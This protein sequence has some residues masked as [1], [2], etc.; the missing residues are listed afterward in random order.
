M[1][2]AVQPPRLA[3][4]FLKLICPEHLF[5]EIEGDLV[6]KFNRDVKTI[7]EKRAKWRLLWNVIR[8]FRPGI[9][10]R[11]KLTMNV[12]QSNMLV[13]N[14][15]FTWRHL[16]KQKLTTA[17]HVIGLTLGISVC[18]LIALFIDQQNS[19]DGYHKNASRIFRVNSIFTEGGINMNLYATPLP[20]SQAIHESITGVEHTSSV[21][22]LF[23]TVVETAPGKLFQEDRILLTDQEYLDIFNIA[24]IAG[25]ARKSLSF[26]HQAIL[27]KSIARKY[28][29][30]DNPIGKTIKLQSK[31]EFTVAAIMQDAP[32]NTSLPASIILP[33]TQGSELTEH[34]DTWYFGGFSWVKLQ[35]STYLLLPSGGDYEK[36]KSQ[37]MQLA[38]QKINANPTLNE[39]IH[40]AFEL[41]SLRDIHFDTDGFGGGPWVSAMNKSWL[42]FFTGIGLLVL[43]LACVNFLNISTAKAATR[44]K[45][46]GIRKSIGAQRKQLIAQFL[47]EAF[48]LVSIASLL[49][50][51]I[52]SVSINFFGDLF[53]PG[54]TIETILSLHSGLWLLASIVGIVLLAGFYPAL[55]ISRFNLVSTLK[56]SFAISSTRGN[57]LFRKSLVAVQFIIS[58]VLIVSV[59]TISEQVRYMHNKPLGLEKDNILS[60][61]VPEIKQG[62]ALAQELLRITGIKEVS[63]SRSAPI[64]LDH[65]WNSISQTASSDKRFSVCAIYGDENFTSFYGLKLLIGRTLVPT[66]FIPD[67]LRKATTANK[68]VV[69]EKLLADLE[70]GTPAEAIGKQFWWGGPAEIIGVVADFNTEPLRYAISPTILTQH[71]DL[72]AQINIKLNPENYAVALATVET[73]W[74]K[75]FPDKVF[76]AAFLDEQINNFYQQED[77]IYNLFKVFALLAIS[78]SCL[79]LWGLV[80]FI[81]QLRTREIGIRKVM[82]ASLRSIAWILSKDFFATVSIAFVI[83]APLA[84]LLMDWI[85]AKVA[86]RIDIGWGIFS[87]AALSI[88][89]AVIVTISTQVIRTAKANPVNALKSE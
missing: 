64:S 57:A 82:G 77:K 80:V 37:L 36:V 8:F 15:H 43:V 58:G 60:L 49:S 67:S 85:L 1:N 48:V 35:A 2:S 42:W 79:G 87:L 13:A 81:T 54:V 84:F 40:A 78:I 59:L 12:T 68:V 56:S 7:G 4:K 21:R 70:L 75:F 72:F 38:N 18:M 25:D 83:A 11:N 46:V 41:Q 6:Q 31:F 26:P 32:S 10:L 88:I 74:K 39:K 3:L 61:E 73:T 86:Y 44:A 20:L 71:P 22:T 17:I 55:A 28:F 30:D 9:L 34:G 24:I 19:F 52:V 66:D 62:P 69:N 76:E 51:V 14:F 45:E 33:Y 47:C 23:N 65:W 89:A 29:G 27:S 50:I 16:R 63:L 5:E 53:G